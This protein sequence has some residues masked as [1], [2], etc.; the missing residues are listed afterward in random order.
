MTIYASAI[1]AIAAVASVLVW[2]M[3]TDKRRN[4]D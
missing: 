3:L 1:I 4:F 2:M